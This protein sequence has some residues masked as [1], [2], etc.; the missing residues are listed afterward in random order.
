MYVATQNIPIIPHQ[1][2]SKISSSAVCLDAQAQGVAFHAPLRDPQNLT[3]QLLFYS[4]PAAFFSRGWST[5]TSTIK[6]VVEEPKVQEVF[7]KVK[8]QVDVIIA[9]DEDDKAR[10][11]EKSTSLFRVQ[12][13]IFNGVSF[14]QLRDLISRARSCAP[15][16]LGVDI[17]HFIPN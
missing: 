1:F 16:R 4:K 17:S 14:S 9:D 11:A 2:H 3:F 6:T 15:T 10:E 7:Q 5:F 12:N 8:Q 13:H